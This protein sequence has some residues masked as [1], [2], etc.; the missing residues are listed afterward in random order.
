MDQMVETIRAMNAQ[1]T[2]HYGLAGDYW[3]TCFDLDI[4]SIVEEKETSLGDD[5]DSDSE[6]EDDLEAPC[7]STYM[8]WRRRMITWFFDVATTCEYQT[9]T[10]EVAI[11]TMDRFMANSPRGN[12]IMQR[13]NEYQL[14]PRRTSRNAFHKITF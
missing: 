6:E 2:K 3:E 9:E 11:N 4:V 10:I 1:E 13:S 5:G 7:M 8:E 14:P 12:R